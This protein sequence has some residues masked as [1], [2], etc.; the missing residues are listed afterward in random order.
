MS[1]SK[2]ALDLYAKVEDLLGVKEVAPK[3]YSYYF[4]LFK[5]I[6]FNSL[7]D[8]GCG[9]G[10]FL[11]IINSI[12]ICNYTLGIDRSPLMVDLATKRGLNAKSIEINQIERKFD[13]A[14]AT[15]DMINYLN[16]NEFNLFFNELSYIIKKNGYFIFDINTLFG[17]SELAVGNF[18]AQDENRFVTIESFYENGIYESYFTLFSK[19]S[20][21]YYTKES[22]QINQYYYNLDCF[23]NLKDW[24]LEKVLPISLYEEDSVDKNILLLKRL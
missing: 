5:E 12:A 6:E 1:N 18:I 17:L 23:K 22:Q 20:N 24:K 2:N 14:V 9:S 7:L 15:F 8:I 13:L 10:D 3:L 11:E 19:S 4:E 21:S 16:K